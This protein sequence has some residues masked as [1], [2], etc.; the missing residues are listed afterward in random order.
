MPSS[1]LQDLLEAL[2]K[3]VFEVCGYYIGRV[4]VPI[5]S[6]GRVKCDRITADVPRKKLRWGGL[7]HRRGQ[8]LYL[9]SEAT[10]AAGLL[11]VALA[12]VSGFLIYELGGKQR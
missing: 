10:M 5:V 2:C 8:Q 12:V 9:T 1:I 6:F 3:P 11:F 7:F 4:V